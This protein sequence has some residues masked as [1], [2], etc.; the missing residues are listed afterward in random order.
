MKRNE[1]MKLRASLI[2]AME[3]WWSNDDG[4]QGIAMSS[5]PLPTM[6]D[7]TLTFMAEAA[8]AVLLAICDHEA[9]LV[10]G[11]MMKDEND[12]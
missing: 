1:E 2:A 6:G 3:Q 8:L 4:T 10:E 5:L 11:G 12:E 9:A 7:A